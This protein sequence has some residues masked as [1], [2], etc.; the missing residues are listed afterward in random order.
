MTTSLK[1]IFN[2]ISRRFMY[3]CLFVFNVFIY[4]CVS[5]LLVPLDLY[6]IRVHVV[7]NVFQNF[8]GVLH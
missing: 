7:F 3:N 4:S 5:L 6:C 1:T 2:E 8:L